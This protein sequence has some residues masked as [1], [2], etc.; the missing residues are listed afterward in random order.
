[1]TP[2]LL[3]AVLLSVGCVSVWADA[4]KGLVAHWDFDEGKGG[5]LHD[6]S[7]NNN[8]G[9]IHGAKWVKCG[10]GY[11][12]KFDGKDD[13]VD[14]GTP[15]ALNMSKDVTLESWIQSPMPPKGEVGI[16]GTHYGGYLLTHYRDHMCYWYISSGANKVREQA[17][18]TEW[19]H[20][21]ATFDG[22]SLKIYMDGLLA[23]TRKSRYNE[24]T[25]RGTFRIGAL[26]GNPEAKDPAYRVSGFFRGMID[27][28][29]VYNRAISAD[30]IK[31]DYKASAAD[32]DVDI[33]WFSRVRLTLHPY[34]DRG[35][36]VA[37]LDYRGLLPL[38]TD[39]GIVVQLATAGMAEPTILGEHEMTPS[40]KLGRSEVSFSLDK[41]KPATYQIRALLRPK[42]VCPVEKMTFPYPSPPV[43]VVS[44]GKRVAAPLPAPP[45]PAN[46]RV[47]VRKGGSFDIN[48]GK[49]SFPVESSFSWPHGGYNLLAASQATAKGRDPLWAVHTKKLSDT[50]YE[51]AA[52]GKYYKLD[53][54]VRIQPDH[55][56]IEDTF[57]NTS[58]AA[59]GILIDN[60]V[61]SRGKSFT[62]HF[63]AGFEGMGRREGQ[64]SPSVF[65]ATNNVGIGLVPLD[66]VFIVQSVV[67]AERASAAIGTEKFAL[68]AKK[69][70]TLEWAVYPNGTGD[71]YDFINAVRKDEDRIG[72]IDGGFAFISKGPF[73]RRN[74]PTKKFVA[75][76]NIKYGCIHCL[77]GAADDPQVSIEGI[78]FMD[79]PNEM[80]L[81]KKQIATIHRKFPD[82]KVF[83]HV[84]QSLYA[85]NN[86]D[87]FPESK[88]IQADGTQAVWEPGHYFSK[89]RYAEGWRWYIYYPTPGN[90]FHDALMKSVDVM[91][92]QIGSDGAFM[93]GFL[94]GYRGRWTYDRWDGCSA[95]IDRKTKTIKRKMASVLL[96]SQPSLVEFCRKVHDKGGVIVA[97]NSVYTRTI[98]NEKYIIHDTEGQA[99]PALH[100]APTVTSLSNSHNIQTEQD[101]YKDVLRKLKWGMLYFYYGEGTLTYD[102]LPAREFPMTFEEIRSGLVKGKQR[103]VTMNSGVYG[104]RGDRSLHAVH[105]YDARGARAAHCFLTTVDPGDGGVRTELK[106]KNDESAVVEKLPIALRS[107]RPI[108][109][110]VQQYD[111]DAI[112]LVLNGERKVKVE[113]RDGDFPIK[114]NAAYMVKTDIV[115]RVAADGRG[116]LAFTVELDGELQLRIEASGKR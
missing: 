80:A 38:P 2:K 53:R 114:P 10:K 32:H 87:R 31:R 5:V 83:F 48:I 72:T 41:L 42:G 28:V 61:A 37:A 17:P 26:V 113:V 106:F 20:V 74:I 104:W 112:R 77:S 4:D 88:V 22:K 21:A 65:V 68:P 95:E 86:P 91:M 62:R 51:V 12:L 94:W 93:D 18:L 96:L 103:V 45:E 75:L 116:R 56:K 6:R 1:M 105:H 66:D 36:V 63:T 58:N 97:N 30:E 90:S 110:V 34:Y 85:T 111:G 100:L 101:V 49:E 64:A 14:C 47:R 84:A 44:P 13:Y 19:H 60:R 40:T 79:F 59:V 81:L 50:Q 15:G 98:A 24:I 29:R 108:N 92:D 16:A 43:S 107:L 23:K 78:E 82:L 11:A 46:F 52:R 55:V 76:R 25:G 54:R 3:A 67:H 109:L 89:R 39:A 99:G 115:K 69:S 8:H 9:K 57:T 33:R 35:Q 71:Y 73:S 70:Y 102:S 27:D 7:G